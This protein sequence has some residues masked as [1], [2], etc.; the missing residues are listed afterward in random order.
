VRRDAADR[1]KQLMVAVGTMRTCIEIHFAP[2]MELWREDLRA[3]VLQNDWSCAG[4]TT[5]GPS[6][7]F[8]PI[9]KGA[10]ADHQL[11]NLPFQDQPTG[12]IIPAQR[13]TLSGM[14][15]PKLKL[16]SSDTKPPSLKRMISSRDQTKRT[17]DL[18]FSLRKP[19]PKLKP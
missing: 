14:S 9:L 7:K 19:K 18:L 2:H 3:S 11:V 17:S 12:A 15:W 16:P 8:G 10:P 13:A 4:S 1:E 6:C 5:S